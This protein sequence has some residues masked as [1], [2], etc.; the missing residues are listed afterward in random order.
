MIIMIIGARADMSAY[1]AG[2]IF[3]E[4][5]INEVLN[6]AFNNQ[7]AYA[8]LL[9]Y[10]GLIL[11][12]IMIIG[13]VC[14]KLSD[15]VCYD[16]VTL[17]AILILAMVSNSTYLLMKASWSDSISFFLLASLA[18]GGCKAIKE[19][20]KKSM[21]YS[22]I[23]FA[24]YIGFIALNGFRSYYGILTFVIIIVAG[25]IWGCAQKAIIKLR[26]FWRFIVYVCLCAIIGWSTYCLLY[27]SPS[28]RDS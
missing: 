23:T 8:Y 20:N 7:V 22:I 17:Y 16:A 12:G 25:M 26:G 15:R 21:M 6:F 9:R 24:L 11:P 19:K 28:P 14:K 18:W 2:D 3:F 10:V 13:L 4:N 1:V 5:A 27:T